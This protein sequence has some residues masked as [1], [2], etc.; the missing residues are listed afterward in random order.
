MIA[1]YERKPVLHS[2]YAWA[3]ISHLWPPGTKL[4]QAFRQAVKACVAMGLI[5]F[6][7]PVEGRELDL[8][9]KR[10]HSTNMKE[11]LEANPDV[12]PPSL[13]VIRKNIISVRKP[14]KK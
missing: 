1:P 10:V 3:Q 11:F 8:L 5:T 14:S 6:K 2:G 9:E 12:V 13:Q 7:R 4:E